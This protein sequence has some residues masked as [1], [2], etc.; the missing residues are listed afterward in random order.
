MEEKR[1]LSESDCVCFSWQRRLQIQLKGKKLVTQSPLLVNNHAAAQELLLH[2]GQVSQQTTAVW[3][4]SMREQMTHLKASYRKK[5]LFKNS[6]PCFVV[7]YLQIVAKQSKRLF[8]AAFT[9]L[10]S[11]AISFVFLQQHSVCGK[12]NS[13][14]AKDVLINYNIFKCVT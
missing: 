5:W 7:V 3:K 13:I 2:G 6:R 8:V 4:R 12:C 10:P 1:A 11:A 9:W 14:W